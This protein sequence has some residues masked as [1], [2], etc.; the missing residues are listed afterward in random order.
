MWT[1][2]AEIRI[3]TG[4][5]TEIKTGEEVVLEIAIVGVDLTVAIDIAVVII[6]HDLGPDLG[7]AIVDQRAGKLVDAVGLVRGNVDLT[8][9]ENRGI[10]TTADTRVM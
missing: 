2:I 3:E 8:V 7:I 9:A 5:E 1:R 6:D 10:P 4:R